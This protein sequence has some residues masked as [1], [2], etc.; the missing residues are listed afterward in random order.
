MDS[1]ASLAALEVNGIP[2]NALE[3]GAANLGRISG[4]KLGVPEYRLQ[5]IR[6]PT[7][8]GTGRAP[9]AAGATVNHPIVKRTRP[10][11]RAAG[12]KETR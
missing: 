3:R 8:R 1:S 2:P 6:S 5:H 4:K 12:R 7:E 9:P 11:W 10:L